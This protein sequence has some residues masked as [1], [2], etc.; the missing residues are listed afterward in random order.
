M[1]DTSEESEVESGSEGEELGEVKGIFKLNDDY[2]VVHQQ[3]NGVREFTFGSGYP[4]A[5]YR[6][7]FE[8]L[9]RRASIPTLKLARKKKC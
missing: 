9:L 1:L 4:R 6:E 7:L 5:Q 2:L 3:G 8:Y